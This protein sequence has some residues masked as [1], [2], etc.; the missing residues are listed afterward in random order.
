[1]PTMDGLEAT[2]RIRALPGGEA[3]PIVAFTANAFDDDRERCFAA[4]MDDFL[5]KPV[6]PEAL[7]ATTL[8]WLDRN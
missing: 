2:Q 5:P 6:V 7:Y 4:G 1:M 3:I 8:K